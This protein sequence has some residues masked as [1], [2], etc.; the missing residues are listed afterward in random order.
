[1]D[2]LLRSP[3]F[4]PVCEFG[5]ISISSGAKLKSFILNGV[6]ISYVPGFRYSSSIQVSHQCVPIS[7]PPL[8]LVSAL[9][10]DSRLRWSSAAESGKLSPVTA[11]LPDWPGMEEGLMGTNQVEWHPRPPS[12]QAGAS[13]TGGGAEWKC[14]V[15]RGVGR[16]AGLGLPAQLSCP[17]RIMALP[18]ANS[19]DGKLSHKSI[20][21]LPHFRTWLIWEFSQFMVIVVDAKTHLS[22]TAVY[23]T[24]ARCELSSNRKLSI[25]SFCQIYSFQPWYVFQRHSLC[26]WTSHCSPSRP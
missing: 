17:R 1:M 9:L 22:V 2:V 4:F 19:H 25:I 14:R 16:E 5:H 24:L 8:R 11:P 26:E 20:E 10:P 13:S 6:Y 12:P 3:T 7:P 18:K 23:R 15:A 21:A